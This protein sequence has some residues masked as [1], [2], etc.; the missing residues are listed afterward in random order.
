[1]SIRAN[2]CLI[3]K[4][5]FSLFSLCSCTDCRI[6]ILNPIRYPLWRLLV[7]TPQ[8]SLCGQT[9][10]IEQPADRCLAK[11][12]TEMLLNQFA[13]QLACPECKRKPILLRCLVRD[14]FVQPLQRLCIQFRLAATSF[15][16]IKR[17][18]TTVSVKSQPVIDRNAGNTQNS[19]HVFRRFAILNRRYTSFTK[20]RKFFMFQL[21]CIHRV[22]THILQC[23]RACLNNYETVNKTYAN[24]TIEAGSGVRNRV[25]GSGLH[26][27]II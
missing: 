4:P 1:M 16:G 3:R 13:N 12:D 23:A 10:L 22:H 19:R 6:F 14:G 27:C 7:G 20:C 5:D 21:A 11:L 2:T 15:I 24:H 25:A 18:P 8:W 17:I 26:Y 9:K